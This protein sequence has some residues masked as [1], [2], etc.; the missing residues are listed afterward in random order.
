MIAFELTNAKK[1][2]VG[3][4][5]GGEGPLPWESVVQLMGVGRLSDRFIRG[6]R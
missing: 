2:N 3:L 1:E 5:R 6:T 4:Q